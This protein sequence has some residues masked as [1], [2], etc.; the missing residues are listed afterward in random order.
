VNDSAL[1]RSG[2]LGGLLLRPVDWFIP[3][4]DALDEDEVRRRRLL[5]AFSGVV[6]AFG[7]FFGYETQRTGGSGI[8]VWSLYGGAFVGLINVFAL[9]TTLARFTPPVLVLVM[10]T[11]MTVLPFTS[12]E[13]LWNSALWWDIPIPL[14]AAFLL[15]SRAAAA[16]ALFIIVKLVLLFDGK[17]DP[18]LGEDA[19]YFRALAAGTVVFT[20]TVL[21]WLYERAREASQRKLQRALS[22]VRKA[23]D[24]MTRLATELERARDFAEQDNANKT[25]FLGTMRKTA[26]NQ[27]SALDETSAAMA[28]MA[29]TF[30]MVGDSVETLANAAAESGSAARDIH[31]QAESNSEKVRQMVAA[32]EEAATSLQAMSFSVQEVA[33]NVEGLSA[34]ADQ[35]ASAMSEMQASIAH[36]ERNARATEKLADDVI[37]DA[38]QGASSVERTREGIV[39]ILAT[40]HRASDTI[41][42]LSARVQGIDKILEVI[43]EV[44]D[45]TQ[46]LSLNAAIIASQAGHH[47]KGFGVV[48]SEIKKLAERTASSTKDI[49]QVVESVREEAARAVEAIA[50]GE[51]AVADGLGRSQEAERALAEIVSS[52]QST[53]QM[54]RGITTATV[55]QSRGAEEVASAMDRLAAAVAQIAAATSEQAR[56]ADALIESTSQLQSL[57]L[58]V[59]GAGRDQREGGRRIESAVEQVNRMV[60]QL[61]VAQSEQTRGSEQVLQAIE[62]IHQDQLSQIE[63]IEHLDASRVE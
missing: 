48:A 45:Q 27:G 42:S 56:G 8:G 41:H 24:E 6:C 21:A 60:Q 26:R 22:D 55:E 30:R 4:R 32:V 2:D 40:S 47:G 53:T 39:N 50:T 57:A 23:N 11:V 15:S 58:A 44:A 38:E 37:G 3:D 20:V 34:V 52:A 59:D 46:L 29:A 61:Q 14:V 33:Q 31:Q 5:V 19:A 18:H 28:Q 43:D 13:R 25:S 7:I 49:A 16:C 35:T 9:R 1:D 63:S 51:A 10:L 36:V 62:T 12:Q 17:A 54:I